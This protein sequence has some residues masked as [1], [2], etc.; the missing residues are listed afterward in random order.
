MSCEALCTKSFLMLA[1]LVCN[2]VIP[3]FALRQF[4]ENFFFFAKRGCNFASF[5]RKFLSGWHCFTTL[6]LDRVA[7]L[8]MPQ[9]NPTTDMD[10]CCGV[11][12]SRSVWTEAY[13][14]PQDWLTVTLLGSPQDVSRFAVAHPSQFRQFDA[15]VLVVYLKSLRDT[16]LAFLLE[17]RKVGSLLK[18]VCVRTI[19]VLQR[20]LQGLRGHVGEKRMF[21]FPVGQ[22]GTQLGVALT[23]LFLL[24]AFTVEG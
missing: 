5:G 21:Q 19:Q 17:L 12:T 1:T 10:G 11:S 2:L 18:E 4:F 8:T 9:S 16:R 6:P 3:A 22:Q 20:L 23:L 14:L 15:P 7:N 13:H 24:I